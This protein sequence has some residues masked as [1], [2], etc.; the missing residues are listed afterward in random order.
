MDLILLNVNVSNQS[1]ESTDGFRHAQTIIYKLPLKNIHL[2]LPW[3]CMDL[4]LLNVNVSNQST[5]SSDGFYSATRDMPRQLSTN[6][7]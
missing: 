6:F 4:I 3:L 5:E 2:T 7:P 1:T